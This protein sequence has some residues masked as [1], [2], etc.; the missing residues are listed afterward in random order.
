MTEDYLKHNELAFKQKLVAQKEKVMA[1]G[2]A[3]SAF[4]M[5]GGSSLDCSLPH[6][7]F[8]GQSMKRY[9]DGAAVRCFLADILK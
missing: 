2:I 6:R 1:D 8:G 5:D 7:G 4:S 3:D 9:A